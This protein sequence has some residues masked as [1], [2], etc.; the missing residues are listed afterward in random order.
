MAVV[1]ER[2]AV[3]QECVEIRVLKDDAGRLPAQFQG[4]RADQAT[5]LSADLPPNLGGAS[6]SDFVD[7][8]VRD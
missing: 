5:A 1:E 2:R 7:E 8:R 3:R 4:D 6:E